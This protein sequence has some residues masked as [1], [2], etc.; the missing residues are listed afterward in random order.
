M[1]RDAQYNS[2]CLGY[3]ENR[4]LEMSCA[5]EHNIAKQTAFVNHYAEMRLRWKAACFL[6]SVVLLFN[7][8]C[9]SQPTVLEAVFLVQL[10]CTSNRN[11]IAQLRIIIGIGMFT[12]KDKFKSL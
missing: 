1:E 2:P 5:N 12:R 6:L 4:V 7:H 3:A 8:F 10:K 9:I 11:L